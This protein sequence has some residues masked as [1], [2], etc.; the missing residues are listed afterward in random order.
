MIVDDRPVV[1]HRGRTRPL[2]KPRSERP[3]TWHPN[4]WVRALLGLVPGLR[5]AVM[6][7]LR[8]GAAL[9][10]TGLLTLGAALFVGGAWSRTEASLAR[11]QIDRRFMIIHGAILVLLVLLYELQRLASSVAEREKLPLAA[12]GLGA[13]LLPAAVTAFACASLMP[14][15]PRSLEACFFSAVIVAV[16]ALPAAI[17]C[18]AE[19]ALRGGDER[20]MFRLAGAAL[21]AVLTIALVLSAVLGGASLDALAHAAASAGF[22]VLPGML[23]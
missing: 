13:L 16:G 17:S 7:D 11:L 6:H 10:V 12:R 3:D 2:Y 19:G 18:A 5:L 4:R 9:L 8:S 14:V 21:L 20:R 23:E 15:A 1:D 22:R